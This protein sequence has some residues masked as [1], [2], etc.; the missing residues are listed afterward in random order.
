MKIVAV[1]CNVVFWGFF[2]MVMVTDGPPRGVDILWSLM[3]FSMPIFNVVV[4][5]VLPS[6]S[7]N[8]QLVALVS[9]IVWLGLACW[10]IIDR[11]PSHPKEAGLT[12][13]VALG[14]LTPLLS[15]AAIYRSLRA[16]EPTLPK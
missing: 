13:F 5:R 2:C 6:P 14:A 16:S 3:P 8:V 4:L 7:R 1:V 10:L 15:A 11:Y 9:N 12:E